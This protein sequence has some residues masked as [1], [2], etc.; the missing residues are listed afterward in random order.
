[1]KTF[2]LPVG[3]FAWI[4]LLASFPCWL[5]AAA[6]QNQFV[7]LQSGWNAVWLEVDPVDGNGA[8]PG[9]ETVFSSPAITIVARPVNP[10]GTA[11]FIS[12]PTFRFNQPGWLVWYKNPESG[13]NTLTRVQGNRAYLVHV[14]GGLLPAGSNT[15]SVAFQGVARFFRPD[16]RAG[17]YN[18]LGF[19]LLSPVSFSEFFGAEGLSGGR[20]PVQMLFRLTPGGNWSSVSGNDLMQPGEAYWIY[21]GEGSSFNGPVSVRFNGSSSLDFG[22]GPGSLTVEDGTLGTLRLNR[23]EITFYNQDDVSHSITLRKLVPG[24]TGAG[25]AVDDLH[26]Y[27]LDPD[28]DQLAFLIGSNRQVTTLPFGAL[29]A[30]TGDTL[31]LGAYFNWTSGAVGRENLYRIEIDHQFHFLPV[32]AERTGLAEGTLGVADAQYTGLWAG[33]VVFDS[34]TSLTEEGRPQEPTTVTAPMRILVEVDTNG[35]ASLLAHVTLMQTKTNSVTTNATRVLVVDD[36]KI[37]YFEGVEERDGKAIGTRLA[38]VGYDMPRN[39][40]P[41]V[42][43]NLAPIVATNLNIPVGSV[44]AADIANYV[45]AQTTRPPELA[46]VY[47]F[48]WPLD[49]GIGPN[50]LV[51]TTNAP[52]NLDVFHRSNPFRHAYHPKHGAGYAITRGLTI[53]FDG[54]TETDL[55]QGTYAEQINGLAAEPIT[56]QGDISL[57]RISTVGVL[58]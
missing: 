45:N 28:P 5:A 35:V 56:V 17:Q 46:E 14:D 4:C 49:G 37:P 53:Q 19:N 1:M 25:A 23:R 9:V 2:R 7:T 6:V 16:W 24:T 54:T 55:L 47:Y 3:V 13:E 29:P 30:H 33:T 11:Q 10:A 42:Q 15:V 48:T 34:V 51:Q 40:D 50:Q 22:T 41:A 27:E 39:F 52:L 8:S 38:T 12:D 58:Q 31:T 57:R 18:L 20:H 36:S 32:T 43:A 44:T 26:L 21:A